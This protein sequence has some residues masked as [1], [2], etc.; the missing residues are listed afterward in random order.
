MPYLVTYADWTGRPPREVDAVELSRYG[1]WLTFVSYRLVVG[2]P[3]R[4]VELRV[5]VSEVASV[6]VLR[7]T[8]VSEPSGRAGSR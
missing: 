2:R 3:R 7:P 8:L 5:H 4:V 6:R 1:R